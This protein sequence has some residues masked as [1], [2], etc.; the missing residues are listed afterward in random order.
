MVS[1]FKSDELVQ[2][3]YTCVWKEC[4]LESSARRA[5]FPVTSGICFY[6]LHTLTFSSK[7]FLDQGSCSNN[8]NSFHYPSNHVGDLWPRIRQS[9]YQD[10]DFFSQKISAIS[11]SL[12]LLRPSLHSTVTRTQ[13]SVIYA[14]ETLA[15]NVGTDRMAIS[16]L[17]D[18][19]ARQLLVYKAYG[20]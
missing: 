2:S 4:F 12:M 17:N 10:H 16:D 5:R 8:G 13:Y 11:M 3:M 14:P 19:L 18:W 6:A 1:T 15:R 9:S 20:L 7:C